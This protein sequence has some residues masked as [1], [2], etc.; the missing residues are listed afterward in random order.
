LRFFFDENARS[1]DCFAS[2]EVLQRLLNV[3]DIHREFMGEEA[4]SRERITIFAE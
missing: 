4:I 2:L 1:D 3:V